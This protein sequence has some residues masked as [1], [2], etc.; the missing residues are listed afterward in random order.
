MPG[1][2][3]SPFAVPPFGAGTPAEAPAPPERSPSGARFIDG[4]TG[5]YAR[6]DDG[7]YLRMPATRQRVLLAL[8]TLQDSSTVMPDEGLRMPRKIGDG[9]EHQA[10]NAI[11]AALAPLVSEGAIHIDAIAFDRE[12]PGRVGATVVYTDLASGAQDSVSV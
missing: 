3:G 1:F 2:I 8:T 6:G 7:E 9:F 11:K 4:A 10:R 12:R 5:D